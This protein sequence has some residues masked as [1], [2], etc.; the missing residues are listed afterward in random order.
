[1]NDAEFLKELIRRKNSID[2]KEKFEQFFKFIFNNIR[3]GISILDVNL[4][5]IGV[6]SLL[7]NWFSHKIPFIGEKCYKIYHNR[8]EP[9]VGCPTLKAV[10]QKR[11]IRGIMPYDEPE[12]EK[13]WHE[14]Y[15]F[16]LYN[17]NNEV[18]AIIEYIKDPTETSSYKKAVNDLKQKLNFQKQTISDQE[19]ALRV[20]INQSKKTGD[21]VSKNMIYN[22]NISLKPIIHSLKIRLKDKEELKYL[23]ILEQRLD[24]IASPFL[25][26]ISSQEYNL[27]PTEI[28]V[29]KLIREGN[30][31]KDIASML[32][33]SVKTVCFHRMNI[34]KK[35]KLVNSNANLQT[36][37]SKL[38]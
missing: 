18:E 25:K 9:C 11:T 10:Q 22:I 36:Y 24:K 30:K 12:K 26:R 28:Q 6:N 34:R 7:E 38:N 20:L 8:Q 31:I 2:R 21:D 16:P 29:A 3:D 37:L 5:I 4:N 17:E 23:E 35:L 14:I 19:T 15:S 27:T 13:N 33:V 32:Q 1:M